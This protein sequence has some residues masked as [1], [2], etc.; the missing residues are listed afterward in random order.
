MLQALPW[1]PSAPRGAAQEHGQMPA[2]QHMCCWK[3]RAARS[4]LH[5]GQSGCHNHVI[6]ILV[7]FFVSKGLVF[8]QSMPT[9]LSL[10]RLQVPAVLATAAGMVP[11][12]PCWDCSDTLVPCLSLP[13]DVFFRDQILLLCLQG[14]EVMVIMY[15]ILKYFFLFSLLSLDFFF[16]LQFPL[17]YGLYVP[18]LPA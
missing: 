3:T 18:F 13:W 4:L 2:L 11:M 9:E 17:F 7:W 6:H 1:G 12:G 15:Q 10:P 8:V 16:W 14:A 5:S